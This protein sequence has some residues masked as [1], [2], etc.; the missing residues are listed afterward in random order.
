MKSRF[1]SRLCGAAIALALVGTVGAGQISGRYSVNYLL[2]TDVEAETGDSGGGG[3]HSSPVYDTIIIPPF[4]FH[5]YYDDYVVV[6]QFDNSTDTADIPAEVEGVPV[7]EIGEN[8]FNSTLVKKLT[9][10]QSVT[11]IA[12]SAFWGAIDL[13]SVVIP[14]N[15]KEIGRDAFKRCSSLKEIYIYNKDC[16]IDDSKQTIS[17]AND[18]SGYSFSGT[19]YGWK[20]ST[21]EQYANKHGY[22]FV[23]LD[24]MQQTTEPVVTTTAVVT[25][26]PTTTTSVSTDLWDTDITGG[27]TGGGSGIGKW[28]ADI[29][30]DEYGTV[31]WNKKAAAEK[32]QVIKINNG[33]TGYGEKVSETSYTL[34]DVPYTEYE[35]FVRAFKANGTYADSEHIVIPS[36]EL[37]TPD[38]PV[39]DEN[40]VVTWNKTLNAEKYAVIIRQG[41]KEQFMGFTNETSFTLTDIPKVKYEVFIR[42]YDYSEVE[43]YDDDTIIYTD[44]QPTIC[45]KDKLG[46]AQAP[47][48][49]EKTGEVTWNAVDNAVSYMIV[50][51]YNNTAYTTSKFTDT[52]GSIKSQPKVQFKLF[53]RSFDKD[54]NYTDGEAVQCG[55]DKLGYVSVPE[56][57]YEGYVTF[58]TIPNAVKYQV[59][60]KENGNTVYSEDITK[61]VP[62]NAAPTEVSENQENTQPEKLIY[63]L[64]SVPTG[65]AEISIRAFD[66]NGS[67]TDGEALIFGK[68]KLGKPG[69]PTIYVNDSGK[70]VVKWDEAENAVK[71]Q[72]FKRFNNKEYSGVV[73]IGNEYELDNVQ[74]IRYTLWIRAFDNNDNYID[75]DEAVFNEDKLGYVPAP[76]FDEKTGIITWEAVDNA[77][78]YKV[79]K[80]YVNSNKTVSASSGKL[81]GTS[82]TLK[83]LPNNKQ[84]EVY[85]KAYDKD[86]NYTR[87][88]VTV[89]TLGLSLGVAKKPTINLLTG[90]IGW[91]KV[92]GAVKYKV[93]CKYDGKAYSS[94]TKA[95][96]KKFTFKPGMTYTVYIRAFDENGNYTNGQKQ[97]VTAS[98][99]ITITYSKRTLSWVQP[100]ATVGHYD[101]K[102]LG[103]TSRGLTT[104]SK[105]YRNIKPSSISKM[106]YNLKNFTKKAK[107]DHYK[108]T[109][110]AYFNDGT[111][112]KNS[113]TVP[114]SKF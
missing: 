113:I 78:E 86:G 79:V 72:V 51:V 62:E 16:A 85:I 66:K 20:G 34:A 33:K 10:P 15:V 99:K 35:L 28:K 96:S 89:K 101:I 6:A 95:L 102:V 67:F 100:D 19:I 110:T 41:S 63:Q 5:N 103:C 2:S 52:K 42:A 56:M 25:T 7:T 27:S 107:D 24:D 40:G 21:A 83:N 90:R 55:S 17:N 69:T 109:L 84:V 108:V 61:P 91:S 74:N 1:R 39:V 68:K 93:I 38:A 70:T 44:S 12:P 77:V 64:E 53:I 97:T 32:Y 81:T 18:S 45:N 8:S 104:H 36:K 29:K 87:G 11:T 9:I 30:V 4:T 48:L 37:G 82:Y 114:K 98:K 60:V 23:A 47:V 26:V 75:G 94:E 111:K 80:S 105:T 14:E 54:G 71:Y 92:A 59:A 88:E 57:D 49:D 22:K 13:E 65:I 31:T 73:T 112:L 3:G 46:C 58:E 43:E 76:E 50:K 106:K